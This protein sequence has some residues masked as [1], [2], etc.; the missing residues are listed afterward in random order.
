MAWFAVFSWPA[1][2]TASGELVLPK[3]EK[4]PKIDGDIDNPI[5]LKAAVLEGYTQYVPQE[6]SEPSERTIG[7]IAYD[8]DNLYLAFRCFDSDPKAVRACLTQRDQSR[9]D[10]SI[11]IYLDTFNDQRRAFVFEVNPRGIQNDGIF[12]ETRRMGRGGGGG[13]GGFD[14]Y[15]RNWDTFFLAEAKFDEKGYA[16]EISIPFKSLRFPNTPV[17][18]WGLQVQRTIRRKNE[19]IYWKPRSRNMNGFLLQAGKITFG[20]DIAKGRNVEVMPVTTGSKIDQGAFKPQAGINLKY[21]ITSDLTAD[22]TYNP[23]FSQIEADIPQ[24]EVNQR[25]PLYYP[26]KRPFFLEGKDLFDM[27]LELAFTR[28]IVDPRWGIKLS[29]KAGKTTLAFLSAMDEDPPLIA[30]PNAPEGVFSANGNRSWIS[31]FRLRQDLM[32]ESYVGLMLTDKEMGPT[33]GTM[34]RN[35]TRVAGVDGTFKFASYNRLSFQVVGSQNKVG[36]ASTDIVPGMMFS[37]AHQSRHVNFSAD[38]T[39]LPPDFEASAGFFPR[40][41]IN[42]FSARFGYAFL[43]QNDLLL[44]VTP[45]V[46]YRRTYDFTNTLTDDEISVTFFLSGWRQSHI[47]INYTQ[48]LERYEGVGFRGSE[49]RLNFSSEPLSWLNVNINTQFGDGINYSEVPFLGWKRNYSLR[50]TVRPL[51]NLRLSYNIQN[52]TFFKERGG[53]LVYRINLLSQR[54]S[55]Q[56]SKPLSVRFNIDWNDYSR[57]LYASFLFSYELRPGTVFYVGID[58]SQERNA[59][60]IFHTIGRY[61]FVKFSYWWRM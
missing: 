2:N 59:S 26:E 55:Y 12:T 32:A 45:S 33:M 6:G 23:D 13:S 30:F 1:Q 15:D 46:E 5:W 9:S 56:I 53:E 20:G 19:E 43:P 42:A 50:F 17:Q 36:A 3:F 25:Y 60:G 4:A 39:S 41:G 18:T 16:M 38:F 58:D 54:L 34:F 22:V 49:V 44:S 61:Y 47:F 51:T 11:R 35:F 8:H 14:M 21:G 40:V 10:D 57:Q 27:P 31:L 28:R 29:G 48:G 7:Y 24:I 52:N 37:L